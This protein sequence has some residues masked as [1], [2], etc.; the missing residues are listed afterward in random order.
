MNRILA[1]LVAV[2]LVVGAVFVRRAL[3]DDD[4]EEATSDGSSSGVPTVVCATEVVDACSRLSD[5]GVARVVATEAG[6]VTADRL[7][8]T[9]DLGA[10]VWLTASFW[11]Q[12]ASDGQ[13]RAQVDPGDLR[14]VSGTLGRA[15][16]V[17]G[18][19]PSQAETIDQRC[20]GTAT[21]ACVGANAGSAPFRVGVDDA[22]DTSGLAV[23]ADALASEVGGTPPRPDDLDDEQ[24][25]WF[26]HFA[27][28]LTQGRAGLT[29]LETLVTFPG[30]FDV[31]GGLAT[32][33]DGDPEVRRGDPPARVAVVVAGRPDRI[34]LD[35][36]R[37]ALDAAG[38]DTSG[39]TDPTGLPN[40]G[41][42]EALRSAWKAEVS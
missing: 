40:S 33:V 2:G 23:V 22:D 28:N 25:D 32:G 31:A 42:M 21:W 3:D 34:D 27:Q 38:W 30:Q 37:D 10:D 29:S 24:L 5:R 41:V 4:G 7:V 19:A 15:D 20:G 26:R 13:A 14:D 12:I 9:G 8:A 39:D 18:I 35:E 11:P 17:M 1:L 16:V 6:G 36:V